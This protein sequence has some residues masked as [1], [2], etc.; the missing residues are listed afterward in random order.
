M[1][2]KS[3]YRVVIIVILFALLRGTIIEQQSIVEDKRSLCAMSQLLT[4]EHSKEA[5][6]YR[7]LADKTVQ[8]LLC[9]RV[10]VIET[11][12]SGF[13]RVRENR[14][15]KLLSLVYGRPCTV[16]IGP[17][18]KAPLYHFLPGHER[19]CL[20]TVGCNL[21]C[22]HCHN[23]QISQAA[24]GKRREHRLSPAEIVETA[25]RAGVNSISFTYTEPT[26]FY[27]Y[28][29]DISKL[30]QKEGIR[31]S[32]VSNGYINPEPLRKLLKVTDAVKI[33]LKAFS[34][35]FYREITGNANLQPV[36]NTLLILKE[37]EQYF[38]IVN[39]VIP[40]LNDSPEEIR[41]LCLWIR[42]NLGEEVPL[43]FTR[44]L[45]SYRLTHLPA[46]PVKTLE[47]AIRIAQ[48][49]GLRYVY[50]GNVPSHKNN[51]TFCPSCEEELIHRVGFSVLSNEIV[52]GNCRFC[53][54]EISGIWN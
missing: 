32:I 44:F 23:W 35:E 25:K 26:V 8:C 9:P 30:A 22:K 14:S 34:D 18:E 47:R 48:E 12:K 4:V 28:M 51:S 11:G 45:P 37:E 49:K 6:F 36:L 50:I 5:M 52:D 27:E 54:G 7:E 16:D 3:L 1:N 29:Y 39:L 33:D 31:T 53:G 2:C 46:T 24:P 41:A 21:S 20:A 17:I 40:S 10:C 15:G 19:L 13:C 43:H 42:D 38:E